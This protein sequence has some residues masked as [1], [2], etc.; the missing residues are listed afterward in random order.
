MALQVQPPSWSSPKVARQPKGRVSRNGSLTAYYLLRR[1]RH[2]L[3]PW[4]S[5]HISLVLRRSDKPRVSKHGLKEV[6]VNFQ[7]GEEEVRLSKRELE[8]RKL[9]Q[10]QV[11]ITDTPAN[12]TACVYPNASGPWQTQSGNNCSHPHISDAVC[13]ERKAEVCNSSNEYGPYV[14]HIA[15]F[16]GHVSPTKLDNL[17][18]LYWHARWEPPAVPPP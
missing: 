12:Y 10:N 4:F 5:I 3:T 1:T 13:K 2:T 14:N 17:W 11:C 18:N 7:K 9:R 15:F 8:V 16:D 6:S